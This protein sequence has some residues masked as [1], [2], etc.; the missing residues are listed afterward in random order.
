MEVIDQCHVN[1]GGCD[2]QCHNF[3]SG[4]MCSCHAGYQLQVDLTTCVGRWKAKRVLIDVFPLF[5]VA[6][7][8][9][10]LEYLAHFM[11]LV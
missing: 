5:V 10:T 7:L 6:F 9:S 4:V 3:G 11:C 2:H 8:P 1:N